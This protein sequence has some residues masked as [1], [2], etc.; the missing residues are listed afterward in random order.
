MSSKITSLLN[1][2]KVPQD[3]QKVLELDITSL[4]GCDDETAKV[5]N[6]NNITKIGD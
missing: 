2:K 6:Q 5:L 3:L 1:V 4:K